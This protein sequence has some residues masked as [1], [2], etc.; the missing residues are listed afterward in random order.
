MKS[1]F[2]Y[3]IQASPSVD[4]MAEEDREEIR[5]RINKKISMSRQKIDWIK[6]ASIAA[7]LLIGISLFGAHL[8]TRHKQDTS[9]FQ[10]IFLSKSNKI[11]TFN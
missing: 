4:K 9:M 7:S 3:Q 8:I 11:F 10:M 2:I 1:K 5:S 6:I